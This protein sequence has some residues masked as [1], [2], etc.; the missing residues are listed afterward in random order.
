MSP[1]GSLNPSEVLAVATF[2]VRRIAAMTVRAHPDRLREAL[3]C[4]QWSCVPFALERFGRGCYCLDSALFCVAVKLRQITGGTASPFAVLSCYTQALQE[5]QKALQS[6]KGYSKL[7]L[8]A[9]TQLLAVY[10]M[11]DSLDNTVWAKHIAGAA[12]LAQPAAIT[13]NSESVLTFAQAAPMFTDAL[14]T[15]NDEFFRR[16][17][18]RLIQRSVHQRNLVLPDNYRGL[19][20]CLLE[21]PE[22]MSAA[23]TPQDLNSPTKFVLLDRAHN[24]KNRL[25]NALLQTHLYS[26][27]ETRDL[28]SFDTLGMCLAA[29][30]AL[31]RLIA[32]LRP[33]E[34]R[35]RE[36]AEDK[37]SELC[38][39]LLQL[40][41]GAAEAYPASDLMAAF[42]MSKCQEQAGFVIVLPGRNDR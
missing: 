3:R 14:L 16:Y 17:P 34:P 29:L 38:A 8:L 26:R 6:S 32:A 30:V 27:N 19:I 37:T 33:V 2:H 7:D 21:L 4:R 41:L 5:L 42:Q 15:G 18:W 24:L 12:S 25:R 22:L 1:A 13:G 9:T 40:E 11:L 20:S 35:A 23:N 39:Q 31:D 10:E 28:E 36:A